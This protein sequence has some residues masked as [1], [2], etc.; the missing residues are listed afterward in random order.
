MSK[1]MLMPVLYVKLQLQIIGFLAPEKRST[2]SG[3]YGITFLAD[4]REF[5]ECPAL[6]ELH[7]LDPI[8][9]ELLVH[10]DFVLRRRNLFL[11]QKCGNGL[12]GTR[13]ITR[14]VDS[15]TVVH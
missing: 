5:I 8:S 9:Q 13:H 11:I 4:S 1:F 2:G 7:S 10:L 3:E 12:S 14:N 6:P 15:H